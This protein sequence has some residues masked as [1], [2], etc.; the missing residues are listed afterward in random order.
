MSDVKLG[1]YECPGEVP[2]IVTDSG[3]R[4]GY[5]TPWVKYR[6]EWEDADE[7]CAVT[8]PLFRELLAHGYV[9]VSDEKRAVE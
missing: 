7:G 1:R 3:Q 8:L 2:I 6:F 9:H 4:D 5:R